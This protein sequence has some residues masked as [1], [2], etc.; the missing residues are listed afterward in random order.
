LEEATRKQFWEIFYGRISPFS[1]EKETASWIQDIDRIEKVSPTF[2]TLDTRQ[3]IE[4]KVIKIIS[5]SIWTR[6][7]T[8]N[9]I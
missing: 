3:S 6:E 7:K 9:K 1:S 5:T 4:V 2:S 8:K